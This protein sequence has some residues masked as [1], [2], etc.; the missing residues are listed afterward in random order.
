[1]RRKFRNQLLII[2]FL[3]LDHIIMNIINMNVIPET[4][5]AH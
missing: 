5:R 2:I 3:I 1:M 4:R